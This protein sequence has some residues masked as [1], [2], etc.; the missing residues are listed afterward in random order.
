MDAL[1][2][3]QLWSQIRSAFFNLIY[4]WKNS[5]ESNITIRIFSALHSDSEWNR[6]EEKR[7]MRFIL[8]GS[9]SS[10]FRLSLMCS[11]TFAVCPSAS[12]G[13]V[14]THIVD[15]VMSPQRQTRQRSK[16][17][18]QHARS[19]RNAF[20]LCA[21]LSFCDICAA[22]LFEYTQTY[23]SHAVPLPFHFAGWFVDL[24]SSQSVC[25]RCAIACV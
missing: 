20:S 15:A 12:N 9:A 22:T 18:M 25:V 8:R 7:F 4:I 1:D 21:F 24:C 5:K 3:W 10:T 2:E 17:W 13:C 11:Y 14:F 19:W 23:R 16:T 6:T